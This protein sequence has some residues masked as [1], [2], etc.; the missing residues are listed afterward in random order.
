[1]EGIAKNTS[2][3]QKEIPFSTLNSAVTSF[4]KTYSKWNSLLPVWSCRCHLTHSKSVWD[5]LLKLD[6]SLEWDMLSLYENLFSVTSTIQNFKTRSGTSLKTQSGVG[7]RK[8]YVSWSSPRLACECRYDFHNGWHDSA[9]LMKVQ[10][11]ALAEPRN[12]I[13]YYK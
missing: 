10:E 2:F 3:Q 1:M 5:L 13:C 7:C 9:L 12:H 6:W 8:K 11:A 4:N